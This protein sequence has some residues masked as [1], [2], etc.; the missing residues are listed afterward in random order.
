M[1]L[2][3]EGEWCPV[4]V[5]EE[6][7]TVNVSIPGSMQWISPCDVPIH[8]LPS[9]DWLISVTSFA[10]MLWTVSNPFTSTKRS[11]ILE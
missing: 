7:K 9:L 2:M 5:A 1:D 10:E 8:T 11:T 6:I 3:A 4:C